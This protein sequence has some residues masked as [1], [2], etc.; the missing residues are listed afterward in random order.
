MNVFQIR[1]LRRRNENLERSYF[2][3]SNRTCNVA[4]KL[5]F[6]DFEELEEAISDGNDYRVVEC[7]AGAGNMTSDTIKPTVNKFDMYVALYLLRSE[8]LN[9]SEQSFVQYNKGRPIN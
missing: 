2:T 3:L 6:L 1:N 4:E 8:T 5:G 7:S 9:N